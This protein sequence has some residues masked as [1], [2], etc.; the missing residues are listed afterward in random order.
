MDYGD[1]SCMEHLRTGLPTVQISE[2]EGHECVTQST[3]YTDAADDDDDDWLWLALL[4]GHFDFPNL[5]VHSKSI[6]ER[7]HEVAPTM[8]SSFSTIHEILGR[9]CARVRRKRQ[10]IAA[11]SIKKARHNLK[12]KRMVGKQPP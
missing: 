4:A 12:L 3:D 10:R 5:Y 11:G 9:Q 1:Q 6:A 8:C 2:V 7:V